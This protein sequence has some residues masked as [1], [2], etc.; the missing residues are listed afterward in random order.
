M[1]VSVTLGGSFA[2]ATGISD[3]ELLVSPPEQTTLIMPALG[4]WVYVGDKT[5]FEFIRSGMALCGYP[6]SRAESVSS[7]APYSGGG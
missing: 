2:I 1:F 3:I 5:F 7:T 4:Q 6:D